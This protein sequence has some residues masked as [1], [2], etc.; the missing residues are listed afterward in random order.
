[1][2]VSTI[3]LFA[4]ARRGD[5][6]GI[7]G[8]EQLGLDWPAIISRKDKIVA[9]WSESKNATPAKLGVPVLR[10]RAMFAGPHEVAVDGRNY[11]AEKIVIATGSKPARPPIAPYSRSLPSAGL[12]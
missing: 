12:V 2:L 3:E 7:R 5:H 11:S 8:S 9:S 6:L 4:R 10:G 1:M